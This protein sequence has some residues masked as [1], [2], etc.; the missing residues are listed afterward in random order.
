MPVGRWAERKAVH[1]GPGPSLQA[2]TEHQL[3]RG[4]PEQTRRRDAGQSRI[5]I[6]S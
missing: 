4:S 5:I 1:Q 6:T 2:G 3:G